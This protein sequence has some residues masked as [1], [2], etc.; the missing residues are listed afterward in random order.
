MSSCFVNIPFQSWKRAILAVTGGR[1]SAFLLAFIYSVRGP[2]AGESQI[3]TWRSPCCFICP[4]MAACWRACFKTKGRTWSV[5][6]SVRS[7]PSSRSWHST[8]ITSSASSVPSHACMQTPMMLMPH[9]SISVL[10]QRGGY[11]WLPHAWQR[12][13]R[14]KSVAQCTCFQLH[15]SHCCARSVSPG[16]EQPQSWQAGG[17]SL[18]APALPG[19]P[20]FC[21]SH[22]YASYRPL[23]CQRHDV[24]LPD[25]SLKATHHSMF[26]YHA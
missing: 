11:N 6:G 7:P 17:Q 18:Q 23:P 14:E 22:C 13:C 25:P 20:L 4:N 3:I 16:H 8:G 1:S 5:P 24:T 26:V 21:R 2:Q 10:F 15:Q 12:P 9:E 19:R